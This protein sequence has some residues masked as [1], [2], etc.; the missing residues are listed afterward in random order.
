MVIVPD[1]L[2]DAGYCVTCILNCTVLYKPDSVWQL[3]DLLPHSPATAQRF[4]KSH[5]H[6]SFPILSA[7]NYKASQACCKNRKHSKGKLSFLKRIR[8]ALSSARAVMEAKQTWLQE[9][10]LRH[11]SKPPSLASETTRHTDSPDTMQH[12]DSTHTNL[13]CWG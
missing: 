12:R 13:T 10:A 8:S 7:N 4:D 9:M 6:H 5:A 11:T 3:E 1:Q 2:G